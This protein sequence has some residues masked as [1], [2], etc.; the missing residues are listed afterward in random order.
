VDAKHLG[1]L[2]IAAGLGL[3]LVGVGVRFGLFAWFGRLPGDLRIEGEPTRVYVPLTSMLVVS[4][5]LGLVAWAVR[6]LS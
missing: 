2:V 3:V 5:A 1:T 4:L 6:K